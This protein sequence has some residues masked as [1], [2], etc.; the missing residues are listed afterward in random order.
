MAA[1]KVICLMGPTASGKTAAAIDMVSRGPYDII[2]VDSAMIYRDMDIGTAKPSKDELAAAPHRLIDIVDPAESYSLG[3][4]MADVTRE[5]DDILAHDKIPLLVG[6]T[7]MYFYQLQHGINNIPSSDAL[8]RERITQEAQEQGWPALHERLTH[9]D[10]VTATR[11]HPNDAQRISRALEIFEQ[12]GKPLSSWQQEYTSANPRYEFENIILAPHDRAII[13][14]RIE[15]RFDLMLQQ[16]FIDEVERLYARGDLD[17][18]K[19]SIRSV[20]Y[21]QAWD[22]LEGTSDFATMRERAI[23]ATRQ[24]CKRQFTWLRRWQDATWVEKFQN[25]DTH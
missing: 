3:N 12:T 13:H 19:P 7:M 5:I 4:F 22:Y 11:L 20:G 25:D 23:V 6:G 9:V 1:S 18:N 24:L 14:E 21:R 15:K 8:I 17:A 16:G 10:P 2:S